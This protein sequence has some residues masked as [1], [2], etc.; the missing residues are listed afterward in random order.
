MHPEL[1][2]RLGRQH[3]QETLVRG[4]AS[5]RTTGEGGRPARSVRARLGWLLVAA[6]SR[7]IVA[8]VD[9]ARLS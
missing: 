5:H 3:Q 1:I 9:A 8:D 4:E 6:G 7:L 2:E